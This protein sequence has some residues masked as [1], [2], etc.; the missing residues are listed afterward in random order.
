MLYITCKLLRCC[1]Y[2]LQSKLSNPF[3]T[4]TF[5]SF[6]IKYFCLS[7]LDI[8]CLVKSLVILPTVSETERLSKMVNLSLYFIIGLGYSLISIFNLL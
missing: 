3:L 2:S 8:N 7:T 1:K 5:L 6:D 4:I